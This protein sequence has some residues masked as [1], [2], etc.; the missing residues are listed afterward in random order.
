LPLPE[1]SK[2]QISYNYEDKYEEFTKYFSKGKDYN[3]F[4][5][6]PCA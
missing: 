2:E 4:E 1:K 5:P 3:L 6:K